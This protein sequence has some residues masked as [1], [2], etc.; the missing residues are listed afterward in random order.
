MNSTSPSFV[1]AHAADKDWKRAAEACIDGLG[2]LP[3]GANLGFVYSSDQFAGELGDIL[4]HLRQATGVEDWVGSLGIGVVSGADGYFDE[5]A[6]AVMVAAFP[7]G[8]FR[9]MATLDAD[10][11]QMAADDRAWIDATEPTFAIVHGDPTNARTP[12]L[13]DDLADT[14]AG[15]LVGGLT[16]SRGAHHQVAGEVT[17]GG[18]SGVLFAP[19]V[20]VATS[21]SQGCTPMAEA[22]EI[23]DCKDNVLMSLDGRPALEVFKEDI[24][25]LLAHDL[26]RVAGYVHAALPIAGTDTGDY[27]VRNLMAI[28]PDRGWL[29]IGAEVQPGDRVLF[30][31]RDPSSA[32][33]DMQAML[34]RLKRRLDG[35]PVGGVYFSCLARGPSMFGSADHEMGMIRDTLGD[36]PVVGFFGEGE[37]SNCRLYG[38][39]GVLAVFV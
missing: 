8:A 14:G 21:L 9:V 37:I 26:Q 27:T 31:R 34:D 4:A 28:D 16:S 6:L 30:V 24:G 17:D 5:A 35:P 19:T 18:V 36:F 12:A 2:T 3:A 22:H 25:E 38:Y 1:A 15:F 13:V 23:T 11:D 7:D 39:T 32:I 20:D 29:A 33:E 10:V